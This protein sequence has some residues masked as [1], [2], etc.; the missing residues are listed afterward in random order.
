MFG[1]TGWEQDCTDQQT[2]PRGQLLDL[3]LAALV[4][5]GESTMDSF[6]LTLVCKALAATPRV[7]VGLIIEL[8]DLESEQ[9]T[10]IVH[11]AE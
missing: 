11:D 3:P 1:V 2:G 4:L 6:A 9:D 5:L 8:L 10:Y 7:N